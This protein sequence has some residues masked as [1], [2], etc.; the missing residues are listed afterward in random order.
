MRLPYWIANA[1]VYENG[2]LFPFAPDHLALYRVSGYVHQLE[3]VTDDRPA[4]QRQADPYAFAGRVPLALGLRS[5]SSFPVLI[6]AATLRS[7][8]DGD[9][10]SR[11]MHLYDGGV[12]DY[13]GATTALRILRDERHP[14][15]A[16]K[17]LI[18]VDAFRDSVTPFSRRE[19]EPGSISVARRVMEAHLD[20]ARGRSR[21]VL[22]ALC[23]S[24]DYCGKLWA[25]GSVD[26]IELVFLSF[27]D[28]RP[29]THADLKTTL[30]LKDDDLEALDVDNDEITPFQ[31]L[32]AIPSTLKLESARQ[33]LL[34]AA[35]RHVVARK[36][37]EI[38]EAL[39]RKPAGL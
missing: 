5:S 4:G 26:R 15:V 31:L 3:K 28:L 21:E 14:A 2:A 18:V 19:A 36:R 23:R 33:K 37:A 10:E 9:A 6:S 22:G 32:R 17:S 12:A 30:G 35:G 27:D 16:R 13:L 39:G 1:T 34:I 38:L 8:G 24:E 25:P 29:L 20:S 7:E 11:Y